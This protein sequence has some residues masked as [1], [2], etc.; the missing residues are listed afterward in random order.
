MSLLDLSKNTLLTASRS[1]GFLLTKKAGCFSFYCKSNHFNYRDHVDLSEYGVSIY[2]ISNIK[3]LTRKT[4]G[5][6][7]KLLFLKKKQ[8]IDGKRP[9]H[10]T[11]MHSWL[12]KPHCLSCYPDVEVS[13][14]APPTPKNIRFLHITLY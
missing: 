11:P 2:S 13:S 7:T 1:L 14:L 8:T 3:I 9:I 6:T 5:I 12:L 10:Y 4:L